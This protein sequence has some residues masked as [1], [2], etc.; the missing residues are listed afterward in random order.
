MNDFLS[1][2]VYL[3]IW[4]SFWGL[5][6]TLIMKYVKDINHKLYIY[7][8]MLILSCSIYIFVLNKNININRTIYKKK[9][10]K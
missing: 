1:S 9:D 3:L 6:D 7:I 5:V 2:F 10:N 8:T 4:I